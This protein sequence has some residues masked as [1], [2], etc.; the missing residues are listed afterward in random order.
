VTPGRGDLEG[1]V[2]GDAVVEVDGVEQPAEGALP[3]PF[4]QPVVL[5]HAAGCEREALLEPGGWLGAVLVA[6]LAGAD[7]DFSIHSSPV[8]VEMWLM[9]SGLLPSNTTATCSGR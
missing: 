4:H 2:D 8:P 1:T 9:N 3:P 6:V 7:R 5:E